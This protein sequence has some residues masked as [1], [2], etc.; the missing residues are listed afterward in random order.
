MTMQMSV[1]EGTALQ[2]QRHSEHVTKQL[3][4]REA[5]LQAKQQELQQEVIGRRLAESQQQRAQD[6]ARH[7]AQQAQQALEV[8]YSSI[9]A[10]L[11]WQGKLFVR[12]AH[13]LSPCSM[14]FC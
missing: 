12:H 7:D 4:L 2:H 9:L 6:T 3:K 10:F 11:A 14:A 8:P 1:A 13:R 5:E